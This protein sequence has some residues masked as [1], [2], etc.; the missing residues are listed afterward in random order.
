MTRRTVLALAGRE[1]ERILEASSFDGLPADW[2]PLR[3]L[4]EQ[5]ARVADVPATAINLITATVQR[6]L[7]MVGGD[8]TFVARRDSMCGSIIGERSPIHVEDASHDP[9]WASKPFVDGRWGTIRFYGSHPLVSSRGFV[10]GT[11]CVIDRR[12]RKLE[13]SQ[14]VELDALAAQVVHELERWR[15]SSALATDPMASAL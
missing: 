13:K 2:S 9:R 12:P 15:R 1:H 4:A 6:S 11:L 14:L 7:V 3:L 10:I 8:A 5:A